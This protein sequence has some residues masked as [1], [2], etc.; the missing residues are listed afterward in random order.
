ML[1]AHV[2]LSRLFAKF[3]WHWVQ[4]SW[5][6]GWQMSDLMSGQV[7]VD[8]F[9]GTKS[10]L[11]GIHRR[12]SSWSFWIGWVDTMVWV[13]WSV[14][15]LD[16]NWRFQERVPGIHRSDTVAGC[17]KVVPRR[18]RR[19]WILVQ[20]GF[21]GADHIKVFPAWIW[22]IEFVLSSCLTC[23]TKDQKM[24][25]GPW[26]VAVQKDSFGKYLALRMPLK[27]GFLLVTIFQADWMNKLLMAL[28]RSLMPK[29]PCSVGLQMP[30]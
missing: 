29:P 15:V 30:S 28:W 11:A 3:C 13:A 12:I 23:K 1:Q 20:I 7:V 5:N 24:D 6:H 19:S 27:K 8:S 22:Y 17:G 21:Q 9:S 4:Y 25:L 26:L 14:N 2:W 16:S 10:I 18:R